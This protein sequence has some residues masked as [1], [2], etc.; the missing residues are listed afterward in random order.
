MCRDMPTLIEKRLSIVDMDFWM[1]MDGTCCVVSLLKHKLYGYFTLIC[2]HI[3]S[4]CQ[5]LACLNT[6]IY[7]RNRE[8]LY[9][10][11]VWEWNAH[12]WM[13]IN[14]LLKVVSWT[15]G[16]TEVFN[17]RMNEW[18]S[19]IRNYCQSCQSSLESSATSDNVYNLTRRQT[20]KIT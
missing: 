4:N 12:N 16:P 18:M 19:K 11:R 10:Y 5:K 2:T 20:K 3:H 13:Y 17:P 14:L 1:A 8:Q 15:S 6:I 9:V 7:N